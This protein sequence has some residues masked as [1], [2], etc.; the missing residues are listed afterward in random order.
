MKQ[1]TQKARIT[2]QTP[3][4]I[5]A[6]KEG[7][8]EAV[9][10]RSQAMDRMKQR[11][12]VQ[13]QY[14]TA[15]DRANVQQAQSK[16]YAAED[17]K[18]QV[19]RSTA[20]FNL[21]RTRSDEDYHTQTLNAQTDFNLAKAHQERDFNI[22][23]QRAQEAYALSRTRAYRDFNISLKRQK[24]DA[25]AT[26]TDPYT[27]TAVKP[28]W[29]AANLA[30]N[31]KQ[32]NKELTRQKE[33]LT[34]VRKA[35]LT[36]S[37]IDQ[38][39]L[40][41]TENAQQLSQLAGDFKAD[42][43]LVGQL[44]ALAKAKEKATGALFD[45]KSNKANVRAVEDFNK[46]L[47][48]MAK[49]MDI[50]RKQASED[51]VKIQGDQLQAFNVQMDRGRIAYG[52][53]MRRA[54]ADFNLNMAHL[55]TDNQTALG[56]METAFNTSMTNMAVDLANGDTEI[57]GDFKT[58]QTATEKAMK[59]QSKSW[60][61]LIKQDGKD[62]I[63]NIN[64]EVL[65]PYN[66]LMKD[67]GMDEIPKAKP[68]VKTSVGGMGGTNGQSGS[69]SKAEG[70]TIPGYSPHSKADNIPINAT[71]GEFMQPVSTVNHY[72]VAGMEAIRQK[73]VPKEIINGYA[74]GGLIAFGQELQK[75]HFQ[76]GEHPL[77]GGVSPTA[78]AKGGQ[79]YNKSGPG[80]GGAI[81]VNFDGKGQAAETKAI[82]SIISGARANNLR[83]LWQ[84][85]GHFD[86]AHF[87]ISTG[88][89][90]IGSDVATGGRSGG[91][92]AGSDGGYGSKK[93]KQ[94]VMDAIKRFNIA[95]PD[96]VGGGIESNISGEYKGGGAS[97]WSAMAEDVLKMLHQP[98]GNLGALL[99][100]IDFESSGNPKAI[101]LT[102]SNAKAGH[103]SKGLMQAIDSTFATWHSKKL[104]NDIWDPKAN[105]YAGANYALHR[106]GSIS[107]IDPRKRNAG[108]DSGGILQPGHT[109]A[110]NGTGKPE[111]VL[112]AGQWDGV[113]KLAQLAT[114]QLT[115]EQGRSISS[116]AC[117]YM[118]V[119]HN[120]NIT[121]DNRN[122]FGDA[123]FTIISNDPDDMARKL[124]QRQIRSRVTQTRGVRR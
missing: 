84:I 29:D 101:N 104:P 12:N 27:R 123:K 10:L 92:D 15:V 65:A 31:M 5:A 1:A 69:I 9:A 71:A 4:G 54:L 46:G 51:L 8:D 6:Q 35:G 14:D 99:R 43:K 33:Q 59:G 40:G 53:S 57:S 68:V 42:P 72:S 119:H 98:K 74:N 94:N 2:A 13:R 30:V 111:K 21:S 34:A 44:N 50:S 45:D 105:I 56:R 61:G 96:G 11:L 76:V 124:E 112:T 117:T 82:N 80:G 23:Q 107:A 91:G 102:D 25:A 90:M 18:K 38:L 22:G 62:F 83:V 28:T 67:L 100:R 75:K 47:D 79:H 108:Y 113:A 26:M 97:Q 89:D 58:L 64:D 49:N 103:P 78:H 120:E 88:P 3:A 60:T 63:K 41:K 118:T 95:F 110:F 66:K 85:A 106:Y 24:E 48:D 77:F 122:D 52:K 39:G 7:Q 86:H 93:A 20:A 121:Y 17:Y 114:L 109:A 55:D 70:G 87:D 37:A 115:K 73:R 19:D 36:D 16:Q 81:D 32:Q 116:G